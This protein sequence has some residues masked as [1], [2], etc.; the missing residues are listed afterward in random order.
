MEWVYV[1]NVTRI[2]RYRVTA[3]KNGRMSFESRRGANFRVRNEL[4]TTQHNCI[5]R[6]T[7]TAD[8]LHTDVCSLLEVAANNTLMRAPAFAGLQRS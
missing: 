1:S 7:E 8:R 5:D 3:L 6:M 4:V 2:T